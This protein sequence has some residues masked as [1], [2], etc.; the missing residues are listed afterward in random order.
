MTDLTDFDALWDYDNPAETESKFRALVPVARDS[1]DAAYYVEL[2]TQI[3]RTEGLQH[4]FEEAHATLD[5]VDTLLANGL[6]RNRAHVRYMLERGRVFN[7]SKHPGEARRLFV[8]AWEMAKAISE[9]ALA[10]DAA[11]MVGIVE[12]SAGQMEWN[13]K[14][15]ALAEKSADPRARKWLGSLYNNL[16]WTHHEAGR[17]AEALDL[18]EKGVRFRA[19]LKQESELRIAKWCV[20]RCL[21]SMGRVDEALARQQALLAEAGSSSDGYVYEEMG[22]CLLALNKTDEARPYFAQAYE[23]LSQDSWL[24]EN[25]AGRVARLKELSGQTEQLNG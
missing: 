6:T 25:E 21:R 1:D 7:S 15:L 13:L 11:H 19:E 24:V 8:E 16:G 9:D 23:L 17:Y 5:A 18:F 12:L 10:V 3:A 14:A 22:E 4:K 2:L 20:A